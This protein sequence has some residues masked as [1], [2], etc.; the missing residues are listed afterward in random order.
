MADA[1]DMAYFIFVT[2]ARFLYQSIFATIDAAQG[3]CGQVFPFS[4]YQ[5]YN[6]VVVY[7]DCRGADR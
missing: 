1:G 6:G 7:D 3:I 2:A 5:F 4:P